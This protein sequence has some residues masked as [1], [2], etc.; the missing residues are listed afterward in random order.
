MF[1]VNL[2]DS[3]MFHE[4]TSL[5]SQQG[6]HTSKACATS[7]RHEAYNSVHTPSEVVSESGRQERGQGGTASC[8]CSMCTTKLN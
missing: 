5:L 6:E 2:G 7:T 8:T 4:H 1:T 3:A